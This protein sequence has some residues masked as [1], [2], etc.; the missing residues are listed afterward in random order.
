MPK[1][2]QRDAAASHEQTTA[3]AAVTPKVPSLGQQTSHIKNK[4]VRAELYG[5]LKHKQKVRK[6]EHDGNDGKVLCS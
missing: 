6:N 1:K 2:R 3:D 5:K 4:L